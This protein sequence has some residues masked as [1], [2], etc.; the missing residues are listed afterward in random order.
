MPP[1]KPVKV[2]NFQQFSGSNTIKVSYSTGASITLQNYLQEMSSY[3]PGVTSPPS[4]VPLNST[5]MTFFNSSV[6]Q[7]NPLQGN[8]GGFNV[9]KTKVSGVNTYV[10]AKSTTNYTF[11][12]VTYPAILNGS[13]VNV[14]VT[15]NPISNALA[16]FGYGGVYDGNL[17][18]WA[19]S[20]VTNLS[21]AHVAD[22]NRALPS[23]ANAPEYYNL[24][25]RD[26][27][28]TTNTPIQITFEDYLN[29]SNNVMTTGTIKEITPGSFTV[30][31]ESSGTLTVNAFD[32]ISNFS[33][34]YKSIN[35]EMELV[36]VSGVEFSAAA[37]HLNETSAGSGVFQTTVKLVVGSTPKITSTLSSSNT[38][39][40]TITLPP[41][42]FSNTTILVSATND[43]GA[44]FYYLGRTTPTNITSPS[45]I[46][47]GQPTLVPIPNVVSVPNV[48]PVIELAYNEPNLAFGT[49]TTLTVNDGTISYSGV[50]VATDS[51][52]YTFPNG[53]SNTKDLNSLG[54]TRLTSANG[55]GTFFI[56]APAT[57]IHTLLGLSYIPS[58]TSI[59]FKIVDLF[60]QQTLTVT[61]TFTT[62][63]PTISIETPTSTSFT[64]S[65]I[66]YLPPVPYNV[67]PEKHYI[68]V[69]VTDKLLAQSVP[70]SALTATVYLIAENSAGKNVSL[71]TPLPVQ[72]TET[73]PG[74]GLFTTSVY[75]YVM[76]N[77]TTH[78]YYLYVDGQKVANLLNVVNGGLL[79]F[80]YTSSSSQQTVNATVTLKPSPFTLIT[81]TSTSVP[82]GRVSVYVNSPGLVEGHNVKYSG[83]FLA[84]AQYAEWNG[85][86]TVNVLTYPVTL[87]EVSA[88]SPIFGGTMVL[89]NSSV[90]S[91]GNLT[92]LKVDSG[93]TVAPSSIV[94]VNANATIGPTSTSSG[95]AA[96]YQQSTI[97]ISSEQVSVKILNP[98]PASPFANL[99]L[100]LNSSLFD[101]L[102]HPA[103]GNYSSISST[104]YFTLL[105]NQLST[106]TAQQSQQLLTSSQALLS[107]TSFYYNNTIWIIK[108]PMTL[109]NGTPGA[110]ASVI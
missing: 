23:Y 39:T 106:I 51:V 72:I 108:L 40:V 15:D 11:V 12:N 87:K 13:Y 4:Q 6:M 24:T 64:S 1:G 56:V 37:I 77:S 71:T 22:A 28:F 30:S 74:T 81:N 101:L 44:S 68:N 105:E 32:N 62:I 29:D 2:A 83:S 46:A 102:S 99:I 54:I 10:Y 88:G 50:P 57:E 41:Y 52:T 84:Y 89:G 9:T 19:S 82:G 90:T 26:H 31:T 91:I 104:S 8:S 48:T 85:G 53:T 103:P 60:A 86:T 96:Y 14:T 67:L 3:S 63:A 66:A 27:I 79:V 98:N 7:A 18:V 5:W 36:S 93:F 109:W 34:S 17:T 47:V 95:I 97:S 38:Y 20:V 61:Y 110:Y 16:L 73:G 35:A 107:A 65:E 45:K 100:E 70:S 94:L 78:T 25:V 59:T 75:Y 76:Y 80:K 49:A 21:Y 55:N 43:I 69:N 42:D 92:S 33:Y 58:G